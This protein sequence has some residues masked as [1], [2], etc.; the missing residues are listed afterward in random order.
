MSASTNVA[1]V[2]IKR[3]KVIVADGHHGGAWKV[4][5]ADFVTAMMAF[6]MLMWLLN[7]TTEKQR[8]GLADYFA[9]TVPINRVSG[10]G[11][12]AFGGTS[13]F[14]E[15]E[16]PQ[17]G[18][19]AVNKYPDN[20]DRSRGATGVQ[21]DGREAAEQEEL[22]IVEEALSGR[23]GESMVS[24]DLLKHIVTRVTDE[25][26]IIELFAV[27]GAPLFEEGGNTPTPLLRDLTQIVSRVS[28]LVSNGIAVTG[29]IRAHPV[30]LADSPVWEL[31]TARADRAR[32]LLEAA[33][34]APDRLRRVTGLADRQPAVR[35]PM[36]NRNNRIEVIL[37][38]NPN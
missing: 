37:L 3:K 18:T 21:D 9:P 27:D 22:R 26:L 12:G 33:G 17:D 8:K 34:T 4:A 19:G 10:G 25:G 14:S 1:P 23:S 6:F 30:V 28:G 29:H 32:L 13:M 35:N 11:D 38:R 20:A 5:Y 7:A 24:D 36:A 16:K 2:I 31:S 15:D